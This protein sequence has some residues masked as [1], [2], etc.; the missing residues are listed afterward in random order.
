MKTLGFIGCG[1]IARS[2]ITGLKRD[3]DY[4]IIGY[5]KMPSSLDWLKKNN[6]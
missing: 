3:S 4:K 2:L 1:H 6:L 5:D